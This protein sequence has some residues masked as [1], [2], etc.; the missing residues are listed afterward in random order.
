VRTAVLLLGTLDTKGEECDYVRR[1]L[2][3]LDCEVLTVDV[4]VL[5]PPAFPPDVRRAAVAGRPAPASPTSR[6]GATGA[7]RLT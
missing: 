2:R 1:R 6:A 3:A 4:G 7:R 5:G